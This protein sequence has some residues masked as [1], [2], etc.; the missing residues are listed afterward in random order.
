MDAGSVT[1]SHHTISGMHKILALKIK[2]NRIFK[3]IKI[4]KKECLMTQYIDDTLVILDVTKQ[5]L[6]Y[7]IEE[8]NNFYMLSESEAKSIQMKDY[9]IE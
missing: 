5:S 7:C 8:I 2:N 4:K 9:C 1:L 3:G 6:Q